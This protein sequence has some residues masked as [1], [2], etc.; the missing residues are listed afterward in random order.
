M[1]L[2]EFLA[3]SPLLAAQWDGEKN[4]SMSMDIST[5]SRQKVWWNCP[6]GHSYNAAIFA[7]AHLERGCPY[8][9]GQ[10]PFPGETDLQTTNPEVAALWDREKNTPLTPPDVTAGSHKKIWWRCEK[11]HSWQAAVFSL[12]SMGNRCPYCAGKK[13]IQGETDIA[14]KMPELEKEWCTERNGALTPQAVSCGQDRKVWWRCE[15]GHTY[16]AVIYSRAKEHGT[17]CPYCKGRKVLAGFNDLATVAPEIAEQWHPTL[18]GALTPQQVTRGS[19][20]QVWWRCSEDHVWKA[21]VYSR[22]RTRPSGC[23]V[24][25]GKVKVKDSKE[26]G[27]QYFQNIRCPSVRGNTVRKNFALEDEKRVI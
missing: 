20:K 16:Q 12:T 4:D 14:T 7:R 11:G 18:N 10:K 1:T 13:V 23:P 22:T 24:C 19:K 3:G 5:Y 21:A 2:S 25:A 17:G 15:K 8:C 26:T 9:S 6:K 27:T